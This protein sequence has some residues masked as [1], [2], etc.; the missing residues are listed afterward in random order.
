MIKKNEKKIQKV[1]LILFTCKSHIFDIGPLALK[2][3]HCTLGEKNYYEKRSIQGSICFKLVHELLVL[4]PLS[5]VALSIL[6][7]GCS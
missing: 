4:G 1:N 6:S 7:L 3:A 5:K 2:H